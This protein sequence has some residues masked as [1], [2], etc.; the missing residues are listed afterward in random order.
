MEE[1]SGRIT[2]E[3]TYLKHT[4]GAEKI[5]VHEFKTTPAHVGVNLKRT[6]NL[7][8]FN[9]PYESASISVN[10]SMPCYKEEILPVYK[11]VTKTV[12]KLLKHEVNKLKTNFE[13]ENING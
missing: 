13:K 6:I 2:V 1:Y 3:R 9:L 5:I 11:E 7:E 12:H 8:Q 10:I 4:D